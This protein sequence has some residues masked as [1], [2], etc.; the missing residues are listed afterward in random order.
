VEYSERLVHTAV[1]VRKHVAVRWVCVEKAET[2]S[3]RFRH[4]VK[5]LRSGA[6]HLQG[7]AKCRDCARVKSYEQSA[8][9]VDEIVLTD[10]AVSI[11][12]HRK[13]WDDMRVLFLVDVKTRALEFVFSVTYTDGYC[14]N[15][16]SA[17]EMGCCGKGGKLAPPG[18]GIAQKSYGLEGYIPANVI[19]LSRVNTSYGRN[20]VTSDEMENVE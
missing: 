17:G 12:Q 15:G 5:E 18:S 13:R 16:I 6:L 14:A 10:V 19:L 8:A 9:P 1:G 20:R 4:C 2:C 3:P 11:L 7:I